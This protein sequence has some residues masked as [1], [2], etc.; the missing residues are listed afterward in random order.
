[1]KNFK[2]DPLTNDVMILNNQIQITQDNDLLSQTCRTVLGTNKG[3]WFNNKNEGISFQN[4]FSKPINY[5]LIEDEIQG[6]LIQVDET[7]KI[8]TFEHEM[9]G[10]RLKVKFKARND[11]EEIVSTEVE[12]E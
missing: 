11:E 5:D 3:E 12:Y 6:G 4:I 2:L 8:Q 1:M 7:L 10:R 9:S